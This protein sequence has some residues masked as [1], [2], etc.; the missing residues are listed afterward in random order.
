M[1]L[2]DQADPALGLADVDAGLGAGN[3]GLDRN[4]VRPRIVAARRPRTDR[5]H[6]RS[7]GGVERPVDGAFVL[8]G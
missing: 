5:L 7:V 2:P 3:G 4:V 8:R 1:F 6:P